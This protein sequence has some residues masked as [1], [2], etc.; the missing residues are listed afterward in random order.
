MY[1][2]VA[3]DITII[4]D[5]TATFINSSIVS[6]ISN[7]LFSITLSVRNINAY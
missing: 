1:I 3:M 4:D 6:T 2:Y 7:M 5:T